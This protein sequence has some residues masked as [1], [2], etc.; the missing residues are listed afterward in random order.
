VKAFSVPVFL[1]LAL[2]L[3]VTVFLPC[4][5]IA[6]GLPSDTHWVLG[7]SCAWVLGWTWFFTRLS[8]KHFALMWRND[9][10]VFAAFIKQLRAENPILANAVWKQVHPHITPPWLSDAAVGKPDAEV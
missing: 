1:W 2:E 9:C 6:L 8:L 3:G 5:L 7:V 4:G 10:L